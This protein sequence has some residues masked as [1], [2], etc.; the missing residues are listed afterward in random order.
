[1]PLTVDQLRDALDECDRAAF[2]DEREQL[3]LDDEQVA[4]WERWRQRV[5]P[6][7]GWELRERARRVALF[8]ELRGSLPH[9][10][11]E[12]VAM[13]QPGPGQPMV[14]LLLGD[15]IELAVHGGADR[16]L[17]LIIHAQGG[18]RYN[19]VCAGRHYW[20]EGRSGTQ[21]PDTYAVY[22]MGDGRLL[23][24]DK[25]LGFAT[26]QLGAA[27]FVRTHRLAQGAPFTPAA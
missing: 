8:A 14:Y 20:V 6:D 11:S 12:R 19:Y 23:D 7:P 3:E 1:M 2:D 26:T 24:R 13:V 5:Y 9:A 15:L 10:D 17:P 25:P 21:E 16:P 18:W 27:E 22:D 4:A